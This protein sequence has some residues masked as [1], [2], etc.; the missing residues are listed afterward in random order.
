L[1]RPIIGSSIRAKPEAVTGL[2]GRDVAEKWLG[3]TVYPG[4]ITSGNAL[5]WVLPNLQ[6]MDLAAGVFEVGASL[7]LRQKQSTGESDG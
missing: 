4:D 2:G 3:T 7:L 5:R 6:N 1:L